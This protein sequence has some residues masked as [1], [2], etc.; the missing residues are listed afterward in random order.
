MNRFVIADGLPYL[1][2]KGKTYA[3]KW[4]E[5]GFTVG[6]EVKLASVPARTFSELSVRAKCAGRLDSTGAFS[7]KHLAER[8]VSELRAYA[9]LNG[10]DLGGAAKKADI[11]SVISKALKEDVNPA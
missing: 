9:A 1:S 8:K 7:G 2:A 6:A 3:V 4:D 10:I 5:R 11:L